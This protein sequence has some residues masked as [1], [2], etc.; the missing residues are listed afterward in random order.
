MK[1]KAMRRK[2][3]EGLTFSITGKFEGY[4]RD[5]IVERVKKVGGKFVD[6]INSRPDYL[7]VG[8]CPGSRTIVASK[9]GIPELHDEDF[10]PY[11]NL[12]L[13]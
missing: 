7:L 5:E 10:Y 9:L 2:P 6:S 11:I 8:D 3:L 13:N 1:K 12:P 4:S